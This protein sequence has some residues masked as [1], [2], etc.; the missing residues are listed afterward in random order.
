MGILL[1][2]LGCHPAQRRQRHQRHDR[3]LGRL[4]FPHRA[5][6]RLQALRECRIGIRRAAALGF[7][8]P[9]GRIEFGNGTDG[10]KGGVH[11]ACVAEVLQTQRRP[12][13]GEL[14]VGQVFKEY[15]GLKGASRE[16][17]GGTDDGDGLTGLERH[18]GE[19][20]RV[21]DEFCGNHDLHAVGG[22]AGLLVDLVLEILDR[23]GGVE[24]DLVGLAGVF[25]IYLGHGYGMEMNA[26]ALN[27]WMRRQVS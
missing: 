7:V 10:L 27:E 1:L 23:P 26:N 18:L 8:F 11:V 5:K 6:Q 22:D 21:L 14:C 25:D 19:V 4:L 13:R 12:R 16:R 3:L 24:V 17:S 2:E 20:V 15:N 9:E